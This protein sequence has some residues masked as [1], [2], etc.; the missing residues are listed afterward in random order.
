M[1]ITYKM[2]QYIPCHCLAEEKCYATFRETCPLWCC[3]KYETRLPCIGCT[4]I[5]SRAWKFDDFSNDFSE[6]PNVDIWIWYESI[7]LV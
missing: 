3:C 2:R 4:A 5:Y 7:W 1:K 6:L